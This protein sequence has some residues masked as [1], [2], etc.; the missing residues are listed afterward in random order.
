MVVEIEVFLTFLLIDGRIQIRTKNYGSGFRRSKTIR[1]RIHNNGMYVLTS[2][3]NIDAAYCHKTIACIQTK[4][5]NL[6]YPE[7]VLHV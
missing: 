7:L 4:H 6:S 2:N 1:I 5:R 3:T